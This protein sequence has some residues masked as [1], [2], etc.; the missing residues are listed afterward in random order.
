[1]KKGKPVGTGEMRRRLIRY[2]R[3]SRRFQ[4]MIPLTPDQIALLGDAAYDEFAE[5]LPKNA[6]PAPKPTRSRTNRDAEAASP[7][8][9]TATHG[10]EA[11]SSSRDGM[12]TR[13]GV[14]TL[15]PPKLAA[16][17]ADSAA[18]AG[19]AAASSEQPVPPGV[20]AASS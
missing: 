11:S 4:T 7:P 18:A 5:L 14:W 19:T 1:M 6:A 10:K 9:R 12:G 13:G 3:Y 16:A 20:P 8:K 17:A 15:Q 2:L